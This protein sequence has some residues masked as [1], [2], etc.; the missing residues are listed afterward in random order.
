MLAILVPVLGRP[1]NV[2]PFLRAVEAS[3]P[4]P[5]RILWIT[6]PDD[7]PEHAA[8]ESV[9]GEML[10]HGG[11]Y[12]QKINAGVKA[13][14]EPLVF[15]AADD[16]R[17]Q[18]GWLGQAILPIIDTPVQVVGINDLIPRQHRP[19]HTTH[20]VMTREYATLPCLD[21]TRG[22]LYEG[23]GA[24]RCD[25]ELIATATKRGVY[26]YAEGAHVLH[27][28]PDVGLAPDDETYRKGRAHARMDTK[29]FVRRQHLWA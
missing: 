10:V 11:N 24:W 1:Q 14:D 9:G 8:I 7:A 6:D 27:L 13:T 5:W 19:R 21:G 12:A 16:L 4:A 23:Y 29:R 3:T 25:D 17:P 15:L 22:P 26:A 18:P 20:F 2:E 28:H